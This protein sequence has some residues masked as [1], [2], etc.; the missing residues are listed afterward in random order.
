MLAPWHEAR[1]CATAVLSGSTLSVH[2]ICNMVKFS[3]CEWS[4]VVASGEADMKRFVVVVALMGSAPA[5]AVTANSSTVAA[6]AQ[7]TLEGNININPVDSQTLPGAPASLTASA[8]ATTPGLDGQ[9]ITSS[10][11]INASWASAKAGSATMNWGWNILSNAPYGVNTSVPL[12][13]TNWT[14]SFTTGNAAG[15]FN[16]SWTLDVS[17]NAFGLQEVTGF[18]NGAPFAISPPDIAPVDGNGSFSVALAPNTSYSFGFGNF[19]NVGGSQPLNASAIYRMDWTI[20]GGG[21]DAGVPEP[22]SWAMLI[23]GFGLVGATA[24]R[25]RAVTA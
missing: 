22:A 12:S 1:A 16:A 15:S 17:G 5:M 19:G 21:G 4:R 3:A 2:K 13:R 14:Y 6:G 7:I 10:S 24:R 25:R 18:F 20:I 11:S 9:Q 8:I 23:A